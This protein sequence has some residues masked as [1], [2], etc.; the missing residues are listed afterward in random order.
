[1]FLDSRWVF[2]NLPECG[3]EKKLE[4]K[5]YHKWIRTS[6]IG[7]ISKSRWTRK[8]RFIYQYE[9]FT[10][11][12]FQTVHDFTFLFMWK[13][14]SNE[15]CFRLLYMW[16]IFEL[17]RKLQPLMWFFFFLMLRYTISF[18]VIMFARRKPANHWQPQM[19]VLFFSFL[20]SIW[21]H[22]FRIRFR[23]YFSFNFFSFPINFALEIG[24]FVLFFLLFSLILFD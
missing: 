12:Q 3:R 13:T 11:I 15:F 14:K 20:F 16:F 21:T 17:K 5:M 10:E 24:I 9:L 18:A 8:S 23:K 7:S 2:L 22:I 1:M 6:H 4:R 19:L